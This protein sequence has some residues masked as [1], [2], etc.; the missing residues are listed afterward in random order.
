MAKKRNSRRQH[1]SPSGGRR[2]TPSTNGQPS[3][4][5][6]RAA[7]VRRA[8]TRAGQTNEL[9]AALAAEGVT[10]PVTLPEVPPVNGQ[11]TDDQLLAAYDA[12]DAQTELYRKLADKAAERERLAETRAAEL[13]KLRETA[14][15]ERTQAEDAR[16]TAERLLTEATA[17][18]TELADREQRVRDR[19]QEAETGFAERAAAAHQRLTEELRQRETESHAKLAADAAE[20]ARERE[21]AEKEHQRVRTELEQADERLDLARRALN[22]DRIAL[23]RQQAALEDEISARAE[24][25]VAESDRQRHLAEIRAE[26]AGQLVDELSEQ[27][28]RYEIDLR[29]F[30]NTDPRQ[31]QDQ[32][33]RVKAENTDLRDRLAA[34]L[35]DDDLDRLRRLERENSEL[36]A[37]REKLEYETQELRG[38]ALADRINNLQVAQLRDA[39]QHYAVLTRGYETRIAELRATV[40]D[41]YR[42]R[43]ELGTPL[44]PKCV[45]M[46]DDEA[47]NDHGELV[48]DPP[49]LAELARNLQSTMLA[50]ST[51]AYRL[52]DVCL[53][54]GGLAMSRLH[55]L[56][57]MSGIGKT[58]LPRALAAALGSHC[59]VVEVQ[60]GWRDRADLFGHH[61]TFEGRFE[62]S[63]FLQ[64]LY[65]AQ[66]PR[67]RHR[68]FFVVL[69]E[70]N[71]SRPEQYFSVILSKL[72]NDDGKPIQLVTKSSGREPELLRE[73]GTSIALP[74]NVWFVGTAN[75]DESTLEFA[76]KT[77]NRAHVMELPAQRPWVENTSA[78][79]DQPFG[80]EALRRAFGSARQRHRTAVQ[81]ARRFVAAL[82]DPLYEH[83]RIAVTPRVTGQVDRFV[84]VVVAARHDVGKVDARYDYGDGDQDGLALAVD[85]FVATKVLRQLRGRYDA[86][87]QRIGALKTAVEEQ[88]RDIGFGGDPVRCHRVLDEEI[89]RREG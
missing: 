49:D 24:I 52:N 78:R 19:E 72:E 45:G 73:G 23:E 46:D 3:T 79:E 5:Q 36:K 81:E 88:W 16:A 74:D 89:R 17:K 67:Y 12:L 35:D 6:Q 86:N 48:T 18:T 31:L 47:L 30:A 61:N 50:R 64:A 68:P 42:D 2:P 28:R 85:H 37:L 62:E 65:L 60:A 77:Y 29:Q 20:L 84:P 14:H 25:A 69:D 22:R 39:E 1:N 71:L 56:E 87:E 44:F 10:E 33:D 76:D 53:M 40:E 4:R 82:A 9:T 7:D 38:A 11:V 13:A 54:L 75:Q 41:L 34:R 80:T 55:L 51:R 57:G 26:S 8:V 66:T 70:M 43:P 63:E 59:T 27:L 83:G 58:S 21:A 15:T 32:L